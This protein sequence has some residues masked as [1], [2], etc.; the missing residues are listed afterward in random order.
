MLATL[1]DI[2]QEGRRDVRDRDQRILGEQAI[3]MKETPSCHAVSLFFISPSCS[4]RRK[5]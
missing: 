1:R 3:K 4:L 5:A 2:W